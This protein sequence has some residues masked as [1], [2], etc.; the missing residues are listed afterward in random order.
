MSELR[1]NLATKEWVIIA[2][3]RAKRPHDFTA[4]P[5]K[6]TQDRPA[7]VPDCPFCPG[8]ELQTPEDVFR[9]PADGAWQ[10]RVF[11]N[12]FPALTPGGERAH[13]LDGVRRRINGVG[14]HEVL[15]ES[16]VHNTTPA[17]MKIE[18][19]TLILRAFQTRGRQIMDEPDVEQIFYFENHGPSA[20]TSL[21]HPHCQLLALPVV[22]YDVRRRIEE[23]RRTFDNDGIC[24]YCHMLKMEL[25]EDR[26]VVAQNA[27]FVAFI[28]FAAFSPF[29]MWI[30]PRRH[31]PT[32]LDLNPDELRSLADIMR[33][34][35]GKLYYGLNDPD[36]NYIIRCAPVRDSC[37]AYLHWYVSIVPRVTKAAGFELGSGMY[38]N[39]SLPEE[40]G[41]FL[42]AQSPDPPK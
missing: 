39:P 21:E 10:V 27:C 14:F 26:R 40:S 42:R 41:A 34:V 22:P 31:G 33:E 5:S 32:F 4:E 16:P 36:Y 2:T 18:E 30:V 17:L 8:N 25:E 15:I 7:F 6:M 13:H 19:I 24:P 12:R 23:L 3:E 29:H 35:F 9:W 20:G 38:I 11:P 37:S 28:P 1:Q